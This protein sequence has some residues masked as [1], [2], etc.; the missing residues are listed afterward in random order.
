MAYK[1]LPRYPWRRQLA[2]T[3]RLSDDGDSDTAIGKAVEMLA[4]VPPTQECEGI[5][6][7]KPAVNRSG[8]CP[9]LA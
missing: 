4:I 3:L 7:S 8:M 2:R 5:L 9:V 1:R 6:R